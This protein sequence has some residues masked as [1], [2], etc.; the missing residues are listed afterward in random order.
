MK[1]AAFDHLDLSADEPSHIFGEVV[2]GVTPVQ[3]DFADFREVRAGVAD[4]VARA[5]A[6]GHVGGA[7]EHGMGQ[8]AGI[9]PDVK[10][11]P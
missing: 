9:D 7:G 6:V 4:Q 8:A 1:L 11:Y 3:Q 5:V 2:A 10:L